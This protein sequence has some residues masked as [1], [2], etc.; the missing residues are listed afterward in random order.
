M[1]PLPPA[2]K[3]ILQHASDGA[4]TAS[5][6]EGQIYVV[7]K[8]PAQAVPSPQESVSLRHFLFVAPMPT[9]AVIGWFFEITDSHHKPFRT[10]AFFNIAAWDQLRHLQQLRHQERAQVYFVDGKV[11]EVIFTK[12]IR[13]PFNTAKLLEAAL[14]H[15]SEISLKQYNWSRAQEDFQRLYSLDEIATWQPPPPL[16]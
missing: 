15:A 3:G 1:N 9:A 6:T 4:L 14:I 16:F 8:L 2:L 12:Q 13:P 11:L 10:N 7:I 5:D